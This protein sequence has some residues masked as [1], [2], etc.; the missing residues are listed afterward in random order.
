MRAWQDGWRA[1]AG[2]RAASQSGLQACLGHAVKRID[3]HV[4]ENLNR[5]QCV[6]IHL[7]VDDRAGADVCGKGQRLAVC[8]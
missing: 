4:F 5:Q 8:R 7:K 3:G 6:A 2:Q 1:G